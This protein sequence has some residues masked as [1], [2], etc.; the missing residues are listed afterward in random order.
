[1]S[2]SS[3]APIVIPIVVAIGLAAW[4]LMVSHA[5]R[6]PYWRGQSSAPGRPGTGPAG[7]ADRRLN[8]PQRDAR[9]VEAADNPLAPGLRHPSG[10]DV[11]HA[12]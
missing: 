5:D 3:L 11:P 7:G 9:T 8:V 10:S 4:L 1:M 6:H 2:G 12:A